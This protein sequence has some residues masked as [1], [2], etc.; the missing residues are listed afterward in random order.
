MLMNNTTM[1]NKPMSHKRSARKKNQSNL[2]SRLTNNNKQVDTHRLGRTAMGSDKK[3]RARNN[4][5]TSATRTTTTHSQGPPGTH[6]QNSK[7]TTTTNHNSK[8]P[9]TTTTSHNFKTPT[10]TTTTNH[11]YKRPSTTN[12]NS[13]T[14]TTTTTNHNSKR[15]TK[16]NS[17]TPT[18]TNHNTKT[19]TTTK[20]K[21]PTTTN[22]NSNPPPTTSH[23]SK[24]PTTTTNSHNSKTPTTTTNSH[25]SK[26]PT[27][28][29][30]RHN[31]KIPTTANHNS[32]TPTTTTNHNSKTP[33]TTTNHNSKTPTTTTNHNSKT[34]TTTTNS[35]NSKTPTTTTVKHKARINKPAAN[36]NKKHTTTTRSNNKT[37]ISHNNNK[38][39]TTQTTINNGRTTTNNHKNATTNTHIKTTTTASHNHHDHRH[40]HHHSTDSVITG[41]NH[42]LNGSQCNRT[43][44]A[45]SCASSSVAAA[46]SL[47]PSAE[48]WR[49]GGGGLQERRGAQ[50]ERAVTAMTP[51]SQNGRRRERTLHPATLLASCPELCNTARCPLLPPSGC[52]QG[53]VWDPCGCCHQ[54]GLPEGTLCLPAAWD[55]CGRGLVCRAGSSRRVGRSAGG[56]GARPPRA[57]CVCAAAPH[58]A[59][60]GSD[61]VTYRSECA[62][63][64]ARSHSTH[65]GLPSIIALQRGA[66]DP[67]PGGAGAQPQRESRRARYNF[68][69]DVVQRAA[70]A[71]VH[72]EI[73]KSPSTYARAAPVSSGSGFLVSDEG[74]IVTNAH[75]VG[76]GGATR[77]VMVTLRGGR[78]YEA[79]VTDVDTKVDIATIRI[80][81]QQPLAVLQLGRSSELRPGEFVVA[82]GS[83][84]ALQNTV[85]TGIVSTAQRGGRELGLQDS[86][87][88]YIQTDAIINYGNSGGPLVNLDGEVIGINALKVA[89]GISF[90]I[91]SDR[92]RLFLSESH[93]RQTREKNEMKRR[94]IGISMLTLTTSLIKEL[95]LRFR[96]FPDVSGGIYVHEVIPGSPAASA[97]VRNGDVVVAVNG[98][99]ATRTTS[100]QEAVQR[101]EKL[102]L[103]IRRGQEELLLTVTPD[104]VT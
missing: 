32:K 69:A 26:T 80:H 10:T 73:F 63:F 24:T 7:T 17:K 102:L 52:P 68:I 88:D 75:V 1:T 60:C 38:Q 20:P 103:L 53:E 90:A 6:N 12:H 15:P 71:V 21:T 37:R 89:A 66:C 95:R 96:D 36:P 35:H 2:S 16:H 77:V 39:S 45:P 98:R 4:G 79:E 54:C 70:P 93:H 42:H 8:T 5:T 61:G 64:A 29:T 50:D 19:P 92:I 43:R 28:T 99:V 58:S 31:S 97:G 27:T 18:T 100:L 84:F 55:P 59:V 83:P 47:E 74:L 11:N 65:Q 51:L 40:N 13:K 86:D 94:Y 87:L 62:L 34:P 44:S 49:G 91:P 23:N 78:S 81:P 101:E 3:R 14:P 41:P 46:S 57:W 67:D 104:I 33:T 22:H 76:G 56:G 48:P 30:N 9:T 82:I 72:I 25:N 85:T